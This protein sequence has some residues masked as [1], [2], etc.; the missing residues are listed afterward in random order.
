[1]AKN[2]LL[3]GSTAP[4]ARYGIWGADTV[5]ILKPN[6]LPPISGTQ[7]GTVKDSLLAA[8]ITAFKEDTRRLIMV[9]RRPMMPLMIPFKNSRIP[10]QACSQS[11]VNTPARYPLRPASASSTLPVT[12]LT[13]VPM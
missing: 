4:R 7:F 13:T 2:G 11:P 8:R 1:M 10:S 9:F 6:L 12:T 5:F 3:A